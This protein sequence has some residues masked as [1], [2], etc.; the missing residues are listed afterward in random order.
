VQTIFFKFRY[1]SSISSNI[2]I[3]QV[4]TCVVCAINKTTSHRQGM[5]E[6]VKELF[7]CSVKY[8]CRLSAMHLPGDLNIVSDIMSRLHEFSSACDTHHL[9]SNNVLAFCNSQMIMDAFLSL[10]ETLSNQGY[11]F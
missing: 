1:I 10:Q 11:R 8:N 6:I 7:W 5:L 2:L 3:R 9:L 4:I